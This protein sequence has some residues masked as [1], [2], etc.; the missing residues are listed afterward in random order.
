M[1]IN[2][3]VSPTGIDRPYGYA[4][5]DV[6]IEI[7]LGPNGQIGPANLMPLETDDKTRKRFWLPD[8]PRTSGIAPIV[9]SD[10]LDYYHPTRKPRKWAD[11]LATRRRDLHPRFARN[12]IGSFSSNAR[13]GEE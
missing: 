10:K 1:Q 12:S 5:M 13:T 9:G 8:L 3:V 2:S 7:L 6:S 11:C 4:P